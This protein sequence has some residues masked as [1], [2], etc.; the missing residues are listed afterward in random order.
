MKERKTDGKYIRKIRARLS[1]LSAAS[2]FALI[3]YAII[4]YVNVVLMM[5]SG[6]PVGVD[7]PEG[8]A[9]SRFRMAVFFVC[10]AMAALLL[11]GGISGKAEPHE[12]SQNAFRDMSRFAAACAAA[13][14]VCF[15][16]YCLLTGLFAASLKVAWDI[17]CLVFSAGCVALLIAV[18]VHAHRFYRMIFPKRNIGTKGVTRRSIENKEG[19]VEMKSGECVNGQGAKRKTEKTLFALGLAEL[20]FSG[21]AVLDIFWDMIMLVGGAGVGVGFGGGQWE[22]SPQFIV[23]GWG[24]VLKGAVWISLVA[25]GISSLALSGEKNVRNA[26]SLCVFGVLSAVVGG[27]AVVAYLAIAAVVAKFIL[28]PWDYI[29]IAAGIACT[30]LLIC[31]AVRAGK[32]SR[33]LVSGEEGKTRG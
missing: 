11:V 31:S 13:A 1:A 21:I 18:A 26:H 28:L 30:V 3:P 24:I 19:R 20:I 8:T 2:L 10:M 5:T 4:W 7:T 16:G 25:G 15:A 12:K 6:D 22:P 14:G 17:F 32:R 29:A 9:E 23:I 27:V 33:L